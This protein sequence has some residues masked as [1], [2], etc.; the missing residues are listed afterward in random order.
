MPSIADYLNY[1]NLQMAAESLFG[2]DATP[3]GTVLTPADKVGNDRNTTANLIAGNRHAS[4]FANETEARKFTDQWTVVEHISNTTTGFSGTLFMN[5]DTREL[6]LSF[7][8]TEF[9]DDAARDNTATN[10]LE[11]KEKGWAFGQ[12]SDMDKWYADLKSSGKIPAGARFSTLK[13]SASINFPRA[14]N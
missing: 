4:K 6:V 1:A 7:R 11:I 9:L 12:I 5:K 3:P 8:S 2:F 10:V 14:H 13:G